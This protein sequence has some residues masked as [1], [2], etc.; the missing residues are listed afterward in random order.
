[1]RWLLVLVFALSGCIE[2]ADDAPEPPWHG[3]AVDESWKST[4]IQPG[5]LVEFNYNRAAGDDLA[6]DWFVEERVAIRFDVHVHTA[7]DYDVLVFQNQTDSI[8]VLSIQETGTYSATWTNPYDHSVVL[9]YAMEQDF[10][11]GTMPA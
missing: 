5:Y 2:P 1:M 4:L 9:F 3:R 7:K 8:G 11:G 6:W 10:Y